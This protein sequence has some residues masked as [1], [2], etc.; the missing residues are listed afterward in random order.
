MKNFRK[1]YDKQSGK[2]WRMCRVSIAEFV[3]LCDVYKLVQA[4]TQHT[5]HM[6]TYYI[7]PIVWI[8]FPGFTGNITRAM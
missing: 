5:L 2:H 1:L 4:H 3:W 7:K 6:H 8:F